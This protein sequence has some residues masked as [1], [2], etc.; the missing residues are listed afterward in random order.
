VLQEQRV[1]L[2]AVHFTHVFHSADWREATAVRK[3]A[4]RLGVT[5]HV[6]AVNDEMLAL[7][8]DPEHGYGSNMNP[9]V[10]CRIMCFTRGAEL[11]QRIGADFLVTGE[12]VGERP[13][14]QRRDAMRHIVADSKLTGLVLRPLCALL[15]EPTIPE[16]KG[17]VVRESLLGISGRSRK[18]QLELA[19][20]YGITEFPSPAGGCLLTDPGFAARMRDLMAHQPEFGLDDVELLKPGRHFRL[21]HGAKAVVGRNK[22]ENDVINSL[23]RDGDLLMAAADHVGPLTLVRAATEEADLETAAALTIRYGKAG[24]MSRA[25]V[26]VWSPDGA[27]ASG[28]LIEV[29]PAG[30]ETISRLLVVRPEGS[31]GGRRRE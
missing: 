5:L 24:S 10:D 18:P 1:P 28:R 2:E 19:A 22:T 15:L 3:S 12:V 23:A 21:E 9:C 30:P 8:R 11:M 14:S 27:K 7:V 29:E 25:N 31:R 13:M 20:L 16:E 17:W 6:E 4:E 26:R